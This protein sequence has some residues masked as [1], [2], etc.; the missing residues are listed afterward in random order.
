MAMIEELIHLLP[1]LFLA[2]AEVFEDRGGQIV[3]YTARR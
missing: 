1:P 2:D 3:I